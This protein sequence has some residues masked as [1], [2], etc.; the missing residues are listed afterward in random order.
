MAIRGTTYFKKERLFGNLCT[1]E[2][3]SLLKLAKNHR[4]DQRV[5]NLPTRKEIRDPALP[6]V[7]DADVFEA[8]RP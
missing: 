3:K 6:S 4:V 1:F 7:A 8:A 5:V 2:K